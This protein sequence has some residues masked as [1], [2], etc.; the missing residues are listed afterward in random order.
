VFQPNRD[1]LVDLLFQQDQ[2]NLER[3]V[4]LQVRVN[5]DCLVILVS[6]EYPEHLAYRLNQ[7]Y[8][9][10]QLIQEILVYLDCLECQPIQVILVVLWF[11]LVLR[12]LD[13]LEYQVIPEYLVILVYQLSPANLEH[14]AFR[15][16]QGYL[17]TQ[18]I[19]DFLEVQ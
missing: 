11:L 1:Y 3:P 13:F 19:P 14:L 17:V 7:G 6:L 9:V 15:Q 8:L 4:F 2:R 5:P 12:N 16:D 10:D 18:E